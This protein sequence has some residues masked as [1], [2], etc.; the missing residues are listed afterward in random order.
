[1]SERCENPFLIAH[2]LTT[3]D[4]HPETQHDALSATGCD[5]IFLDKAS[6]KLARRSELDKAPF[7]ASRPSPGESAL[8]R[9]VPPAAV[10][11]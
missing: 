5:E 2:A 11:G 4:Q 1:L 8:P 7:P 3:R 10:A 6:G 9:S